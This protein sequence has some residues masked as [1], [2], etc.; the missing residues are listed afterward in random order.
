MKECDYEV[1]FNSIVC[2]EVC[3]EIAFTEFDCP[4]CNNYSTTSINGDIYDLDLTSDNVF[5]CERC[6]Q[7]FEIV[8]IGT[9]DSL[10]LIKIKKII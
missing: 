3:N 10:F 6:G 4:V 5:R 8:S 7:K 2:C 1:E 9:G